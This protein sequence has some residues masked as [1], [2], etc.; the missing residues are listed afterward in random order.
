MYLC[1]V[2]ETTH[3]IY[4]IRI[5]RVLNYIQNNL[6]RQF[7]FNS[8]A[9]I[10]HFSPFHF[11]RIFTAFTGESIAKHIRRLKLERAA[12]SLK[13]SDKLISIISLEAGYENTESFSR[14]F[15]N[16]FKKTPLEYRKESKIDLEKSFN[17]HINTDCYDSINVEIIE[18]VTDKYLVCLRHTGSYNE[19]GDTWNKLIELMHKNN[20]KII[21]TLGISYDNPMITEEENI[22]YDACVE[23]EKQIDP[24]PGMHVQK[25]KGGRYTVATIKGSYDNLNI[26]YDFI[27]VKWLGDNNIELRNENCFEVYKKMSPQF[28]PEEY[29]TEIYFPIF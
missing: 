4:A 5:L 25:I 8:L 14:A 9:R 7:D 18:N 21:S 28:N 6:D 27:Y 16:R 1:T 29:L 2:K 10:A 11:H 24:E 22:R 3:N 19:V 15:K 17:S 26:A 20:Y 23:L 13:Y 12:G